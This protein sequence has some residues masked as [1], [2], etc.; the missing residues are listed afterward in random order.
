MVFR[1]YTKYNNLANFWSKAINLV[2]W[3][4]GRNTFWLT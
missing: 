3:V 1:N 4:V 2:M